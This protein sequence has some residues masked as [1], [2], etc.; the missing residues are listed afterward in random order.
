MT[1]TQKLPRKEVFLVLK[2]ISSGDI[3]MAEGLLTASNYY[4][5][6]LA[7]THL[8]HPPLVTLE[9]FDPRYRLAQVI[10]LPNENVGKWHATHH[11]FGGWPEFVPE[12]EYVISVAAYSNDKART[13]KML[14]AG[15]EYSEK[16]LDGSVAP[17]E[18][19]FH[20]DL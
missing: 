2:E 18:G 5:D 3:I 19:E 12:M 17:R 11:A 15:V 16:L 1:A 20:F 9:E 10:H 4:F 6:G 14:K 8:Q 7:R 13:L